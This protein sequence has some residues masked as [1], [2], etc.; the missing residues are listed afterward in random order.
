MVIYSV[1]PVAKLGI[2]GKH[3]RSLTG[4]VK[5]HLGQSAIAGHPL[6]TQ[7]FSVMRDHHKPCQVNGDC[8]DFKILATCDRNQLPKY[9]CLIYV[10]NIITSVYGD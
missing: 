4:R 9:R 5:Q 2:C 3:L 1:V 10:S 8:V 7:P 6:L